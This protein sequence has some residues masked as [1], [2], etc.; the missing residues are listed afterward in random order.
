VSACSSGSGLFSSRSASVSPSIVLHHEEVDAVLV[1]HVV[2]GADVR[3]VQAR[4]RAGFLLEALAELGVLGKMLG[5][6]FDGHGAIE[7]GV[8]RSIDLTH[9]AGTDGGRDLVGAKLGSGVE[10]HGSAY[11]RTRAAS[12]RS[13]WIVS[14]S[15]RYVRVDATFA[16]VRP[17]KSARVTL[18]CHLHTSFV[19]YRKASGGC[20]VDEASFGQHRVT[21]RSSVKGFCG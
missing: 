19:T 14:R 8:V 6:D 13:R 9:A 5:E 2:E 15:I 17:P 16:L 12:K 21:S 7:A 1:T 10:R 3:V 18:A 20:H 11:G 4:H